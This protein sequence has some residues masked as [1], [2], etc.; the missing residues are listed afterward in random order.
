MTEAVEAAALANPWTDVDAA[1]V[2]S[3]L[4]GASFTLPADAADVLYRAIEAD[5]LGEAQFK[6]GEVAMTTRMQ[7]KDAFEDI[8]GLAY[9]KWDA[10]E[11]G[12]VA[13]SKA[14]IRRVTDGDK[15]VD[16]CLWYDEA[17]GMMHSLVAEGANLEGFDI[18]AV[19]QQ[20]T[21]AAAEESTEG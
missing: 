9:D 15:T 7:A 8:S 20:M 18:L 6:L 5:G 12:E 10:E 17:N 4:N 2:E 13:G 19:A 1:A 16:A 11:E 3:L 14:A 21:G